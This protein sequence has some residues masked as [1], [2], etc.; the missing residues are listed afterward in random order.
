MRYVFIINPVAGKGHTDRLLLPA[1]TRYFEEHGGRYHVHVTEHSGDATNIAREEGLVGD[2]V[3]IYACGGEG[4]TF[5]VINGVVGM[6]NVEVGI[7]P[8][9][10]ANDFVKY[11]GCIDDFRD[12]ECQVGGTAFPTDLIRAGDWYA[13]NQCSVGMD[14]MVAENMQIFKSWPLV[15]GHMAYSFSIIYTFFKK[16]GC[17][18][19]ISVDGRKQENVNCLFAV[20][21]NA[22]YYGGGYKS[23]PDAVPGD[24]KLNYVVI[25]TVSRLKVISLLRKYRRGTH[26]FLRICKSGT[27]ELMEI[28][29]DT[30]LPVNLDGEII[31][32][33]QI[34]FRIVPKA[35]KL[36][37]PTV[38]AEKFDDK[39][40]IR[41]A[42]I[43]VGCVTPACEIK[44]NK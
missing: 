40:K 23:A 24:G 41:S 9:G 29:G 1:I 22:P 3:R 44:M 10:T 27:C 25:N 43:R 13:L 28:E 4:T 38:C 20:C 7:I 34:S 14:A 11:F 2:E 39:L 17:R 15:S 21:A 16:F 5:E 6:P 30:P 35:L 36:I 33:K 18:L 8:Y 26:V 31:S 12:I 42:Q 37:I 19:R 32:E